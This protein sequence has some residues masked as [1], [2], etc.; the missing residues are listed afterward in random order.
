MHDK[1]KTIRSIELLHKL[2][3]GLMSNGQL[4]DHKGLVT[5]IKK[6][7]GTFII[8]MK[9]AKLGSVKVTIKADTLAKFTKAITGAKERLRVSYLSGV[10]TK[11]KRTGGSGVKKSIVATANKI[12]ADKPKKATSLAQVVFSGKDGFVRADQRKI[13]KAPDTFRL[14]GPI[15][16]FLGD[17]Q[18]YK[19]AI[20]ISGPRGSGKTYFT[21]D[22]A[23]EFINSGYDVGFFSI[24]QGG[25]ESKDT[26][27]AID[28]G[29]CIKNQ[30]HL[31]VTGEAKDGIDTVK[32]YADRFDVV[33]IDSWQKLGLPNTDFDRLLRQEHPNTIWIVIFQLNA[34]GGMRNGVAAEFDAPVVLKA[35]SV[36]ASGKQNYIVAEKNR[37]NSVDKKYMIHDKKVKPLYE[38]QEAKSE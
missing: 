19:L 4:K 20:T 29:I 1:V 15:G 26:R 36:D 2:C 32:K 11:T 7:T 24:E 31:A 33:I 8:Q 14:K 25:L 27:A 35:I 6:S 18:A 23:N 10:D 13:V 17:L 38:D 30:K 5:H 37:G 21:M 9:A 22:L 12:A 3:A 34:K 16:S 28:S